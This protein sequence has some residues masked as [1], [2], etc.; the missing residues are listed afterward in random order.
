M[1]KILNFHYFSH[2]ILVFLQNHPKFR[3]HFSLDYFACFAV[4]PFAYPRAWEIVN[5]IRFTE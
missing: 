2:K 5:A 3:D 1:R 4:K